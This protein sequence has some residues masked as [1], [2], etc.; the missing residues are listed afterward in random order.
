MTC[1][2][3]RSREMDIQDVAIGG[4]ASTHVV[5]AH[6]TAHSLPG[7]RIRLRERRQCRVEQRAPTA[8]EVGPTIYAC[9]HLRLQS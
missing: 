7:S 8:S 5:L 2:P 6:V 9:A 4:L 1:D 3:S